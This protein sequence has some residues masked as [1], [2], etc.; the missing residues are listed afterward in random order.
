MKNKFLFIAFLLF[1]SIS[2]AQPPDYS[3]LKILYA[4]GQYEKLVKAADKY[5]NKPDL[6]EDA[7]PSVYLSMGLYRISFTTLVDENPLFA[8]SRETALEAL[9]EAFSIDKEIEREVSELDKHAEYINEVQSYLLEALENELDAKSYNGASSNVQKYSLVTKNAT[10]G[11][12]YL[13][14]ALKYLK[15]DKAGA[16]ASWKKAGEMYKKQNITSTENWT[17]GDL[18]I[19]KIGVLTAAEC[20]INYGKRPE[21]ETLLRNFANFYEEDEEFFKK[22]NE[23]LSK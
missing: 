15:K 11:C 13:E 8:D 14:G 2:Y 18:K 9:G 23:L 5:K 22:Y 10:V 1:L 16:N 3:D 7:D 19:T 12:K 20:L 21:A 6:L 17:S 4:E